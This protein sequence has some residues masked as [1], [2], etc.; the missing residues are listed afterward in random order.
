MRIKKGDTVRIMIG[1]D[2]GKS[3]KVLSVAP[4]EAR[5]IVDGINLSKKRSRPKKQGE[6]GETVLVPRPLRASNVMIVCSNCKRAVR[7]GMKLEGAE[8]FRYCKH[9]EARI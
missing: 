6:K 7:I 1:K 2:R 8:K 4:D 5:L 9:C 3:G